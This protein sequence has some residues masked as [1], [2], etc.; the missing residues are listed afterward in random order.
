MFL[1]ETENGHD[2]TRINES[3]WVGYMPTYEPLR[4]APQFET[5]GFNSLHMFLKI[6]MYLL[7]HLFTFGC[8]GSLLW[9]IVFSLVVLQRFSCTE[10]YGILV[11]QPGIESAAPG[12]GTRILNHWT[13]REV[14]VSIYYSINNTNSLAETSSIKKKKKHKNVLLLNL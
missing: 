13:T 8:F 5:K 3:P 11:S 14:L 7:V 9:C 10:A 4:E 2:K 6:L 1:W 12:I